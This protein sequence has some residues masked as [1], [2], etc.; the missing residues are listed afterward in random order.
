[1]PQNGKIING[2][3]PFLKKIP[4]LQVLFFFPKYV[5]MARSACKSLH[6]DEAVGHRAAEPEVIAPVTPAASVELKNGA[7]DALLLD[8]SDEMY[9]A[10]V[11]HAFTCKEI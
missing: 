6:Q 11:H 7:L 3:R 10:E 5:A 8:R 9:G 2:K 1:M 4:L